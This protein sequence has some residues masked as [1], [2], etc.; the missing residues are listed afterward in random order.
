MVGISLCMIVRDEAAHL[1]K[2]LEC[3]RPWVDEICIVDTGSTDDTIQVARAA[4]ATVGFHPWDDDFAAAR[5]A[6]LA[7]ATQ[8]WILVAD[9]DEQLTAGSGPLLK[10]S[11]AS[12]N[13]AALLVRIEN[14]TIGQAG[15]WYSVPRL[16]KNH[17]AI[18]FRRRV[19]ESVMPSL[20]EA[21]LD[22]LGTSNISLEH[23]GY[24][25]R[26]ELE[27][28]RER[29]IRL[30][31]LAQAD[32]PEDLFA[33]YKLA[34]SLVRPDQR[35]ERIAALER[36][37]QLARCLSP[38]ERDTHPYLPLIHDVLAATLSSMGQLSAALNVT[39]EALKLHPKTP[40]LILRLA[41][42]E[43]R[44]GQVEHAEGSLVAFADARPSEVRAQSRAG[45]RRLALLER[46]H[47]A[48]LQGDGAEAAR[49]ARQSV[50]LDPHDVTARRF[51]AELALD[52]NGTSAATD[53]TVGAFLKDF[54]PERESW[55]VGGRV[56]LLTGDV[57][58]ALTLFRSAAASSEVGMEATARLAIAELAGG[59]LSRTKAHHAALRGTDLES[60]AARVVLGVIAG[61][62]LDVDSAFDRILLLSAMVPWL[63]QLV[64]APVDLAA[65][66]FQ[67]NAPRYRDVVPRIDELLVHAGDSQ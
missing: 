10:P 30:L 42:L 45:L 60:E 67:K 13:G 47:I 29:N 52:A 34:V 61:E 31:R 4:G 48:R 51:E 9:A 11:I 59:D 55:I 21:G 65:T 8:E 3:F 7:L 53:S 36:A 22:E 6:S 12:A 50:E 64:V 19:H 35:T 25:V 62:R 38:A 66:T 17:P 28:K 14:P 46:G 54:G 43:R 63:E 27:R 20:L 2:T 41:H 57:T 26:S 39:R 49:Y 44:A 40:E 23:R 37:R 33:I 18:R 15:S 5:N 16:I 1:E 58:T 32:D 24:A 56:A